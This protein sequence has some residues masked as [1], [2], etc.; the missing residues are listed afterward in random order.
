MWMKQ[1]DGGLKIVQGGQLDSLYYPGLDTVFIVYTAF[2]AYAH[3]VA[4]MRAGAYDY[5]SKLEDGA[6]DHLI[7][8]C[9]EGLAAKKKWAS[10]PD[11][12]YVQTKRKQ[13][14]QTYGEAWIAV[15]GQEVIANGK[16]LDELYLKLRDEFPRARPYIVHL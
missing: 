5:V 3:C 4:T 8:S 14:R 1:P 9:K 10:D 12:E 15:I 2:P 13:L 16:S 11:A 6:I 7:G